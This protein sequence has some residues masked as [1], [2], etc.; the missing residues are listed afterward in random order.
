MILDEPLVVVAGVSHP[1]WTAEMFMH[2]GYDRPLLGV[3]YYR[4]I[5]EKLDPGVLYLVRGRLDNPLFAWPQY[6]R[7]TLRDEPLVG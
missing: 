4:D 7:K 1:R 3:E 5:L 2:R 6:L